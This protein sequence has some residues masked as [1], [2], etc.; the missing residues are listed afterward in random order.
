V[1]ARLDEATPPL[2]ARLLAG[3]AAC[4]LADGRVT[5]AE[6]ELLRAVAGSLGLPMPA[7]PSIESAALTA[8]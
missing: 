1:L 4:V 6:A 2:K 5:V 3:A 8:A 7:L